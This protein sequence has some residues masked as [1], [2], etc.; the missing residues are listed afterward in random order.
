MLPAELKALAEEAIEHDKSMPE[1]WTS[2]DDGSL[3]GT[4]KS[5]EYEGANEHLADMQ[6][7]AVQE[8]IIRQSTREPLLA[9]AV[10]A[11]LPFV[12]HRDACAKWEYGTDGIAFTVFDID[13]TCGLDSALSGLEG[14]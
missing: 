2:E 7:D 9:R 6:H 13:C 5:G 12:D 3:W 10:L 1:L 4:V 14:K 11:L 8:M